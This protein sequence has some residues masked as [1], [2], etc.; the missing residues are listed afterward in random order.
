MPYD[1][2][3][4]Q[5]AVITAEDPVVVVLGGAGSGKTTTAAAAA[6]RR[7]GD[8]DQQRGALQRATPFGA[9]ARLPPT[10]RVLFISF[11]R[12]AVAQIIDRAAAVLGAHRR[13]I[14]VVTFHGLAWRILND[15]AATTASRTL[16]GCDRPPRPSSV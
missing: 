1:P 2:T 8:L 6:A 14:D 4:E 16:C 9:V 12:T 11:S 5:K 7:L 10:K 3:D 13:R 15:L